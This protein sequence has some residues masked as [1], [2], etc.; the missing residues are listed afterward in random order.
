MILTLGLVAAGL[1]LGA[2]TGLPESAAGVTRPVSYDSVDYT[3]NFAVR[4]VSEVIAGG[5]T[6]RFD[7]SFIEI[8]QS[9]GQPMS[10]D[11]RVLAIAIASAFCDS[12]GLPA[13]PVA[14]EATFVGGSWVIR[15]HCGT[16]F[17]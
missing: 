2:C 11:D 14:G 12:Y 3:V 1:G 17:G 4:E 16:I 15:N 7:A 8:A 9:D 6:V 13:A 10:D 5:S